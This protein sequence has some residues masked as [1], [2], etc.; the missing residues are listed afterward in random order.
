M[1]HH[2][3]R[4]MPF[5]LQAD[6]LAACVP[7]Q[8]ERRLEWATTH[9]GGCHF[10]YKRTCWPRACPL[11][12]KEGLNGPP[13]TA[14]DAFYLQADV[15]AACVPTQA[16][17]RLEWATTHCG[18]CHFIYKRTCWPRACPLKPKEGLN[19]PPLTAS[20][21]HFI[22]KRTC[23]PRACPLKPKEGLN[24]HPSARPLKPKSA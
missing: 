8:A 18:G 20:G 1:G 5:Y 9:C 22:Y 11:K 7:T 19:G 6:V 14:V 15:L 10:I 4:W 16:K 24:V 3:L 12:P 23:W 17:R 13:L 2:S 21:C